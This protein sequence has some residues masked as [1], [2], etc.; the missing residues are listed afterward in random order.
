MP[1]VSQE[2]RDA[3][4]AQI[5]DAARRCFLRNGFHATSMQDLFAASGL[6]SGAVYLYFASKEDVI[7]AIAEENMRD[8]VALI[9]GLATSRPEDGIGAAI[10]EVLD[11][12][13]KKHADDQLGGIAVLVWSEALRNPALA[14]RFDESL[15]QMRTDFA[16][17][18]REYQAHAAATHDATPE[19]LAALFMSIIPG[20]ILQLSL[21]GP[22][23][24]AGVPD[25]LR[26][27]WP[28]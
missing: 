4:R 15:R 26:A 5:L 2:Y 22:R 28:N 14:K 16:D 25:A 24:V 1:K 12:V 11:V 13:R 17:L 18:V 19:A 21:F 3:R 20:Y 27:L 23:V 6:S 7:L 9:H 10:S 8:V